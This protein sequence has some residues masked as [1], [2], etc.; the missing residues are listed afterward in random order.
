MRKHLRNL[1]RFFQK[2]QFRYG[3]N[4]E[5]VMEFK[6][7]LESL[8]VRKSSNAVRATQDWG[9]QDLGEASAPLH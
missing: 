6:N 1:E 5:L 4:D 3:A 9:S 8:K 2:L 7:E